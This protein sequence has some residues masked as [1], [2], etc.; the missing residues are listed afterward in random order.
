MTRLFSL[1]EVTSN[2]VGPFPRN[3]SGSDIVKDCFNILAIVDRQ[4]VRRM[5][6]I[7]LSASCSISQP[8]FLHVLAGNGVDKVEA[9]GPG[10]NEK[11]T[12]GKWTREVL[13]DGDEIIALAFPN[14]RDSRFVCNHLD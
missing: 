5:L 2:N 11:R 3:T 7:S 12:S 6:P 8:L 1:G 9:F 13:A 14:Q 10:E 4:Q